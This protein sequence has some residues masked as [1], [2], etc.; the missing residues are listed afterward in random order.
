M[1]RPVPPRKAMPF[2]PTGAPLRA[3]ASDPATAHGRMTPVHHAGP[4]PWVQLRNATFHPS[5]FKKMIGRIDPR[6]KNG[7]LVYAYDRDANPFG[8]G[9][10]SMHSAIGLRMLTFDATAVDESLI[11]ARIKAAVALR[12]DF[13]TLDKQTDAYR[14]VHAEGDGLPGLIADRFADHAVVELFNFG[15]YRRMEM[16]ERE[17]RSTLGVSEVLFRA[18]ERVQ[19]GE[20]FAAFSGRGGCGS[21]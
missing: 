8:T 16:L 15:M 14:I 10:L 19:V 21:S 2:P 7:D 20:G 6:A 17:I 5:I 4:L 3:P 13:L 11:A 1:P 12:R 9:L 18:D